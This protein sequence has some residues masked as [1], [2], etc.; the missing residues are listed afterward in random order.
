MIVKKNKS[1]RYQYRYQYRKLELIDFEIFDVKMCKSF[2]NSIMPASKAKKKMEIEMEMR[3]T[4]SFLI[5]RRSR[6]PRLNSKLRLQ[7][8]PKKGPV[9]LEQQQQKRLRLQSRSKIRSSMRLRLR[10][11]DYTKYRYRNWSNENLIWHG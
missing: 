9:V 2:Q 8:W 5:Q 3:N 10:I 4:A 1:T 6:G 7:F 11:T